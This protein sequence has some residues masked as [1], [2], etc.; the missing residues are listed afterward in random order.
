MAAP[1]VTV[2]PLPGAA[3]AHACLFMPPCLADAA[4]QLPLLVFRPV[5][6]IPLVC[7]QALLA[8]LPVPALC[9][10]LPLLPARQVP[11]IFSC[12]LGALPLI[13]RGQRF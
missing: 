10:C 13:R 9:E 7:P 4:A 2:T 12:C 3:A 6:L 11:L 1:V 8:T 5:T